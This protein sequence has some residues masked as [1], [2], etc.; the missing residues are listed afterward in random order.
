MPD[1]SV[2]GAQTR[3]GRLTLTGTRTHSVRVRLFQFLAP[4]A[5]CGGELCR[6]GRELFLH[7]G[8]RP[9]RAGERELNEGLSGRE[10]ARRDERGERHLFI[11]LF[12]A[13]LAV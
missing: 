7:R 5:L 10:G 2:Y 4:H 13:L 8:L 3:K 11:S 9:A 6:L 1:S 12:S